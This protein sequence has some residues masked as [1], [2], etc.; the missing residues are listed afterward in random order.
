MIS[1][2]TEN[3]LNCQHFLYFKIVFDIVSKILQYGSISELTLCIIV[4]F[5]IVINSK[6]ERKSQMFKYF[7]CKSIF[8]L[9]VFLAV[10]I[11]IRYYCENCGTTYAW[12]LWYIYIYYYAYT[13][14]ISISN[15]M[16][17]AATVDCYLIVENKFQF[18][19]KNKVFN[20]IL[21]ISII[22]NIFINV[23]YIFIFKIVEINNEETNVTTYTVV[24]SM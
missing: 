1:T 18:L 13:A 2:T 22:L 4:F 14:F 24:N 20:G 9:F 11:E 3:Q 5:R 12:Q 8:D 23:H 17:I 10:I 16:E 15:I 7:L 6:K 21:I 19:M